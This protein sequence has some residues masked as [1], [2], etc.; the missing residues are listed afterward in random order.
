M[1]VLKYVTTEKIIII[2][3]ILSFSLFCFY[4]SIY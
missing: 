4:F 2:I 3:I 1:N